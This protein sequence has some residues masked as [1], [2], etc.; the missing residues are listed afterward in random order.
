MHLAD[1]KEE[2]SLLN[3][4]DSISY[5]IFLP[6][7]MIMILICFAKML[8]SIHKVP[9]NFNEKQNSLFVILFGW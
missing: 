7:L 6:F 4:L 3:V 1:P 2:V 5:L 9:S 8:G